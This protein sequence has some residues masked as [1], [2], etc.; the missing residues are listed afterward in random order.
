MFIVYWY[1]VSI[2]YKVDRVSATYTLSGTQA[3][4]YYNDRNLNLWEKIT[5]HTL[6]KLLK[7]EKIKSLYAYRVN[8]T[9]LQ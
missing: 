7:I 3:I 1:L 5:F 4:I 2:D 9:Q 8:K 6:N